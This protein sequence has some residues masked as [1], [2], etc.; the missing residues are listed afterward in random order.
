MTTAGASQIWR[1]PLV[2]L[3]LL[4]LYAAALLW[5]GAV[6]T[7]LGSLAVAPDLAR[8]RVCWVLFGIPAWLFL[9]SRLDP[10]RGWDDP[11]GRWAFVLGGALLTALLAALVRALVLD[12]LP[13][14]DDEALYRFQSE[15]L[16]QGRLAATSPPMRAFQ[17]QP[18]LVNDG[19]VYSQYFLGWPFLLLPDVWLGLGGYVN[20]VYAALT[21]PA[22][23]LLG[24]RVG[25]PRGGRLAVVVGASAPMLVYGA[26]TEM[27]HTSATLL[28]AWGTWLALRGADDDAPWWTAPLLGLCMAGAFWIRP[29]TTLGLGAPP[30]LWWLAHRFGDARRILLL[31]LVV[32]PLA[33]LFLY[34][35]ALQ[36]GSPWLTA[37]RAYYAFAIENDLH[38]AYPI[39]DAETWPLRVG[40]LTSLRTLGIALYRFDLSATGWP[41]LLLPLLLAGL[42]DR[43]RLWREGAVFWAMAIAFGLLGSLSP[44]AGVDPFGPVH[45]FEWIVPAVP[46]LVLAATLLE[47]RGTALVLSGVLLAWVGY[48]PVRTLAIERQADRVAEVRAAVAHLEDA[49]V[50]MPILYQVCPGRPTPFVNLRPEPLYG[51][52]DPVVWANMETPEQ[53]RTYLERVFPGRTGWRLRRDDGCDVV[54]EPLPSD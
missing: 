3:L 30:L 50:F 42:R 35:N 48:V 44:D 23:F 43:E 22:F 12:G 14:T 19:R 17:D 29:L 24:E 31:L 52:E 7:E 45:F 46:L 26:A 25:G 33:A 38:Y 10:G 34:V 11:R 6:P 47:E 5:S 8:I 18:F 28:L 36:T 13:V 49:V 4:A 51:P 39:H 21:V 9:A 15:L 54:V 53:E 37:Y 32:L 2:L 40:L 16:A 1:V 41:T 20:A 27:S